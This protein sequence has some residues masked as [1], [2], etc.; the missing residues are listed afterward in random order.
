MYEITLDVFWVLRVSMVFGG[1]FFSSFLSLCV[2]GEL[3]GGGSVAMA[4]GTSDR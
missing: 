1:L 4:V 2:V 3:K